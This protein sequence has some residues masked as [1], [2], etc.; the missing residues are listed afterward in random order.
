MTQVFISYSRRD[1]PFVEHLAKDLKAAGLDV[2]YDLSGLEGGQRWGSEIQNAILQSQYFLIVLSSHSVGSEWVE[3]EFMYAHNL[4]RK[5]V[6][7]LHKDCE[8]PMW[9]SNLHFID[10][11][12]GSYKTHLSDLLSVLGNGKQQ[13]M[14][15]HSGKA[16]L[17]VHKQT[18]SS[19][20]KQLWTFVVLG[21]V[22]LLASV[23]AVFL[24]RLLKNNPT[25]F[26]T[27]IFRQLSNSDQRTPEVGDC[28]SPDV[29]CIGFVTDETGLEW[30]INAQQWAGI[31]QAVDELGIHAEYLESGDST[32]YAL[33][34]E[35]FA[36]KNYDLVIAS[37]FV[38]IEALAAVAS[39]YPEVKF[40][41]AET[42]IP[43]EF[44]IPVGT[45]GHSECIP[46]VM[47]QVF[48]VD[49]GAYLAGYLAAGMAV[50]RDPADPK[51]G[52]FSGA[53]YLGVT[54]FS[55]GFQAGMEA[56]NRERG[57]DV[58]LV[59][60]DSQTG[61]GNF[62]GNFFD[63]E[64]GRQV[65]EQL[66]DEGVDV[67]FPVATLL[68]PAALSVADERGLIVI[69]PDI[70]LY[71]TLSYSRSA[72]L[73][74]VRKRYDNVT[75]NIIA[76]VVSSNFTGCS[77][78]EADL[79]NGGVDLAPY[80][81]FDASIP[82]ELKAEV[83]ALIAQIRIGQVH[84]YQTDMGCISYPAYCPPGLYPTP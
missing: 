43:D 71:E 67:L 33:N 81:D 27:S 58:S 18:R 8:P 51:L 76:S 65:S 9:V 13:E 28:A 48:K 83:E 82:A 31:Q 23:L 55:V 25:F 79:S 21:A 74:S 19:H 15:A 32:G 38:L 7:I 42:I 64:Q 68:I 20:N 17:P 50:E 44:S 29:F 24:P 84:D 72:L 12:T 69:G 47:G 11:R 62:I 73:T 4:G 56:Y 6:P 66:A 53:S 14:E 37:N 57:T 75:Y 45:V 39:E 59:G 3:K 77:N 1:L 2:W 61:E 80:H 40:T 63:L 54:I 30:E 35:Q 78:Y 70:D 36:R 16:S 26:G 52:T 46:N 60:W 22:I 41:I 34:L 5:I 49:Q 10:M